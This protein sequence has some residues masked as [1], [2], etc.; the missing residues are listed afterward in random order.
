MLKILGAKVQIDW[1]K[2]KPGMSF[3][4]PCIDTSPVIDYLQ[5]DAGRFRYKIVCKQ[6]VEN[7]RYGLRCWR[8]E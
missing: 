6:V 7:Q 3:F 4:V 2:V 5:W 8:V 1:L